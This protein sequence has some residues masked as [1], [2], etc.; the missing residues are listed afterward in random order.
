MLIVL[1]LVVACAFPASASATITVKVG[2]D[3]YREVLYPD[4]F[5]IKG[6]VDDYRGAMTLEVDEFPYEGSYSPKESTPTDERGEFVYPQVALRRNSRVRVRA[7]SAVSNVVEVYVHPGVKHKMR[8]L[9][10]GR[11]RGTFTYYGHPG[12]APPDKAFFVYIARTDDTK[13]R[14]LGGPY[15]MKQVGDGAWRFTGVFREPA[16][17]RRYSYVLAYCTRGLSAA[18]Y[19]RFWPI[20]RGCGKSAISYR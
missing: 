13:F 16:S 17:R 15:R 9:S 8:Q 11:V 20:D 4:T 18:G 5:R 12:F 6:K 7:G 2:G 3:K 14:R 1:M 10:R 19:G